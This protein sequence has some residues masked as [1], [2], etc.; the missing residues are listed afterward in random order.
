M[1]KADPDLSKGASK[2]WTDFKQAF[3][4]EIDDFSDIDGISTGHEFRD[5][6]VPLPYEDLPTKQECRW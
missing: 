4:S 6:Y 1:I 2:M 5:E 3:G